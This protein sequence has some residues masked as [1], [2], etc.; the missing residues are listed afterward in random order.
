MARKAGAKNNPG[1]AAG[2]LMK[3][4]GRPN[5]VHQRNINLFHCMRNTANDEVNEGD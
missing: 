5:N 3:K 4:E 1:H 2:A